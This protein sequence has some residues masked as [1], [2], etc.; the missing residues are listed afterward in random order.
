MDGR[1]A[2]K[3]T[4]QHLA[5]DYSALIRGSVEYYREYLARRSN[6]KLPMRRCSGPMIGRA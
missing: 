6:W 2:V 5:N 4:Y 1:A 3:K